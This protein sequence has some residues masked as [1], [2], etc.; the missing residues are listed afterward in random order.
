MKRSCSCEIPSTEWRL[1]R[2]REGECSVHTIKDINEKQNLIRA[3]FKRRK[4]K[5]SKDEINK[6]IFW[7]TFSVKCIKE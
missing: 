7:A 5:A 6:H 4:P 2:C 1:A 3:C